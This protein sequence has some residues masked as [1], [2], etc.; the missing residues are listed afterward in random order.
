MAGEGNGCVLP[1]AFVFWW[2]VAFVV[3][4]LILII[5]TLICCFCGEDR[6]DPCR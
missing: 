1:P 2:T 6:D 5:V 4:I 3:L